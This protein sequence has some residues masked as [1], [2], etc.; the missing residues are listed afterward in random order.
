MILI[1]IYYTGIGNAAEDFA[2]EMIDAGLVDKIRSVSGNLRYEYFK[3]LNQENT[4]LL[5][6]CWE[7]QAALDAHHNSSVMGEIAKL[8]DKYDLHMKVIRYNVIEDDNNKDDKFIR[9]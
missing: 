6:D 7:N 4:I 8:R 5:I 2:K 3:P 9:K 1:N